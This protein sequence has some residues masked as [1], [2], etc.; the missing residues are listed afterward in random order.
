METELEDYIV[1]HSIWEKELNFLITLLNSY[2][3]QVNI[4]WG[5]PVFSITNKNVVGV[6]AFK[7]YVGLWFFQ[8]VFL[9]DEQNLMQNAQE[10]KTKAMRQWRFKS[11]EELL[12][13]EN[14]INV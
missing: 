11:I 10:G 8:G 3:M 12:S 5:A 14:E 9:K 1:K 7:N 4:K 2:E 6:S 13:Y